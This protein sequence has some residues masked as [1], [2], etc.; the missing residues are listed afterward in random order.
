[1][2]I[3]LL[4]R[5]SRASDHLHAHDHDRVHVTLTSRERKRK[6]FCRFSG[7][8][9]IPIVFEVFEEDDIVEDP[10]EITE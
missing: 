4:K 1:M 8:N 3:K 2:K 5:S 7:I 10:I 6:N 9:W